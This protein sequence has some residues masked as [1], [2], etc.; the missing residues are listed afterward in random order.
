MSNSAIRVSDYLE[1]ILEAIE[2]IRVYTA[3]MTDTEFL[4]NQLVQ[5]GVIRNFEV[6]GEAAR[7]IETNAPTFAAIHPEL[8]LKDIYLMRNRL[9]HGY[10]SINL[11]IVW[12]TVQRDLPELHMHISKA[13][14]ALKTQS[15]STP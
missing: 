10:F 4:T 3:G 9:S 6:M 14:E 13:Y 1:H 5:D 15:N 11:T 12:I 8:R 2:R 7:N